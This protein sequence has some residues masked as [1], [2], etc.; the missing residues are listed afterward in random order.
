MSRK[1]PTT[2][3]SGTRG[4]PIL[5]RIKSEQNRSQSSGNMTKWD[6]SLFAQLRR[7]GFA[8]SGAKTLL[9]WRKKGDESESFNLHA[10]RLIEYLNSDLAAHST[11]SYNNYT[12]SGA[13]LLLGTVPDYRSFDSKNRTAAPGPLH[14]RSKLKNKLSYLVIQIRLRLNAACL[15]S[16]KKPEPKSW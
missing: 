3:V 10:R 6:W 2:G 13:L 5:S 4:L 15:R 14:T 12:F 9:Q 1:T 7:A 16:G 11:A 8:T